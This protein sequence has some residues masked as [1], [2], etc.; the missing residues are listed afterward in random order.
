MADKDNQPSSNVENDS[1]KLHKSDKCHYNDHY[2]NKWLEQTTLNGIIHVFKGKSKIRK[3]LWADIF[4]GA[5]FG[6]LFT[7][8]DSLYRFIQK[9]TATTITNCQ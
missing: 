5:V 2:F 1:S 6:C 3:I 9:P 4:L 7:A 8:G